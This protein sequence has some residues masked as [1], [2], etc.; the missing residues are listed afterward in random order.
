MTISF[1]VFLQIF[2]PPLGRIPGGDTM[3]CSL[4]LLKDLRICFG[5]GCPAQ[6]HQNGPTDVRRWL[7]AKHRA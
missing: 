6:L 3:Q 7:P 5:V 4:P 2:A 1:Q